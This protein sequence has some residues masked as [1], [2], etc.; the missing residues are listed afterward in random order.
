[1][2]HEM[3]FSNIIQKKFEKDKI[4]DNIVIIMKLAVAY[5]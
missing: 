3:H 2:S 4:M 5:F 1:M